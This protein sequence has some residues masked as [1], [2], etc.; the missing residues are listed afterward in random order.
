MTLFI[1]IFSRPPVLL[2]ILGSAIKYTN[3][4]SLPQ[5]NHSQQCLCLEQYWW[6]WK[7]CTCSTPYP[8]LCLLKGWLKKTLLYTKLWILISSIKFV[9]V[10][11]YVG[12]H[13]SK[14]C[15]MELTRWMLSMLQ[16]T[17]MLK[18]SFSHSLHAHTCTKFSYMYLMIRHKACFLYPCCR[19]TPNFKNSNFKW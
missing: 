5:F 11:H 8:F 6:R 15:T 13:L 2:C 7:E 1:I 17:L 19:H 10:Q 14:S 18:K 16:K 9:F 4:F 3:W 12:L